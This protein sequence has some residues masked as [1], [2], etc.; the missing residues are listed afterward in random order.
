MFASISSAQLPSC[1][2]DRTFGFRPCCPLYCLNSQRVAC[3]SRATEQNVAR[4]EI[5]ETCSTFSVRWFSVGIAETSCKWSPCAL[6]VRESNFIFC[7]GDIHCFGDCHRPLS[8]LRFASTLSACHFITS[9]QLPFFSDDMSTQVDGK[10][11]KTLALLEG[12]A[13]RLLFLCWRRTRTFRA[14]F[15]QGVPSCRAGPRTLSFS[16]GLTSFL[17]VVFHS[18]LFTSRALTFQI[19]LYAIYSS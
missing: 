6:P 13:R 12:V 2:Y 5:L 15:T 11:S 7:L 3:T 14:S 4:S 1:L 8:L 18:T 10:K 16:F 17:Q 9:L 19:L